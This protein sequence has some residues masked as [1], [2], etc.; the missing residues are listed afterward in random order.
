MA[1]SCRIE[2]KVCDTFDTSCRYRRVNSQRG[3]EPAWTR[4]HSTLVAPCL[5]AT[6]G[7]SSA[8]ARSSTSWRPAWPASRR[9]LRQSRSCQGTPQPHRARPAE[10]LQILPRHAFDD[11][12]PAGGLTRTTIGSLGLRKDEAFRYWFDFGDGWWHQVTVSAIHLSAPSGRDPK[13]VKKTGESPPQYVDWDEKDEE[14]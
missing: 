14:A 7:P 3:K 11:R 1:N 10:R 13:V 2:V 8:G 12:A 4:G 9:R 5:R 6:S